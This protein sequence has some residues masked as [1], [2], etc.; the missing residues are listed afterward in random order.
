MSA[1][2]R[3]MLYLASL[4]TGLRASELASLTPASFE[5]DAAPPIVTV[6]AAYSK[7]RREDQVPLHADLVRR[8]RPWLAD[9]AAGELLWPGQWAKGKEAGVIL[10][11]D[12]ESARAAWIAEATDQAAR[13]AREASMFLA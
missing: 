3:E 8:L 10:K 12:L 11:E 2:D 5:L 13:Q 4:F 6:A 9:K 7:H 1:V